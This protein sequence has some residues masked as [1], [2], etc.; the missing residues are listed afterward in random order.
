MALTAEDKDN[1]IREL[2]R[3]YKEGHLDGYREGHQVGQ[4]YKGAKGKYWPLFSDYIRGRDFK[5]YG[6]CISCDKPVTDWREFDAGHFIPREGADLLFY[7]VS[8]MSTAS[9]SMITASKARISS[10]I[11]E[12]LML[13]TALEQQTRFIETA[14]SGEKPRGNGRKPSTKKSSKRSKIN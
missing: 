5:A 11:E 14:T 8:A 6:R 2:Q 13:D 10:F 4:R 9:A 7:L 3:C 12:G 1:L